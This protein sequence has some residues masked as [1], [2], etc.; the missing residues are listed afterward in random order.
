MCTTTIFTNK[1]KKHNHIK[2]QNV[3]R[4]T[5]ST[6]TTTTT[7]IVYNQPTQ[8]HTSHTTTSNNQP[9]FKKIG[10]QNRYKIVSHDTLQKHSNNDKTDTALL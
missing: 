2:R 1:T 5:F 9:R 7:R 10:T 6:T 3:S 8:P 4:E